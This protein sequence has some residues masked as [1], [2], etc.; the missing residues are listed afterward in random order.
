MTKSR[1]TGITSL[2]LSAVLC[3]TGCASGVGSTQN[4]KQNSSTT[5]I[6]E[7]EDMTDCEREFERFLADKK[8]FPVSF[9]YGGV[10][11]DGL[12]GFRT[13]V[14]KD[15][16]DGA[17][18]S[19]ELKYAHPDGK[20]QLTVD[21]AVYPEYDA[22]EWTVYFKNIGESNSAVLS[23]VWGADFAFAGKNPILKWN[24]GDYGGHFTPHSTDL[25]EQKAV[26]EANT[27]RSSEQYMPYFDL[28]TDDGGFM[29][30]VGWPG[31][32]RTEFS[33]ENGSTR[34][35]GTGTTGLKTY[36]KPGETVRTALMA[37]VRYYER[38]EDKAI[39][40]WRRWYIDCNMPYETAEKTNKVPA[41]SI[42]FPSSDTD[43]GWYRGGSEYE[44]YKTWRETV[45]VLKAHDV[46]FDIH[47]FDAGWYLNADKNTLGLWWW[48][49]GT[50][51]LDPA[52]WPGDT[53]KEYNKAVQDELGVK[54]TNMW[55]ESDRAK[56]PICA[57]QKNY[58]ADPS[59]YLPAPGENYL[60]NYAADGASDWIFGRITN[61]M[62]KGGIDI[63]RED[64]NF[65]PAPAFKA[66]DA[67]EGKNRTGITENKYFI[68]KLAMWD[69]I[70]AWQAATGRPTFIEMQAAGGNRLDLELFRR[71]ISFFRSDSDIQ[72]DPPF[73][74]SKVNALN[75]WVPYGGVLF[76]KLSGSD[77]TNGRTKYQWRSCYASQMAVALQFRK[78]DDAMWELVKNGLEE[79]EKYKQ[80]VLKDFYELTPWKPL[81]DREQWVARM[82]FDAERDRGVLEVFNAPNS[83]TNVQKIKLKGVD[84]DGIYTLTDPDG[85]NGI[86][87]IKGS[88]LLDG[89]DIRL[90]AA[91]SAI[92]WI[93]PANEQRS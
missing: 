57:L 24:D 62:E 21:A 35:L 69:R 45:D 90:D 3:M 14:R 80:F 39:N 7:S 56:G 31:T 87:E 18:R 70:L 20:L 71:S 67:F 83:T 89:I 25:S 50:W 88:E 38:D 78:M 37:F 81:Y 43:H 5:Y 12:S 52:K 42:L 10:Y 91:S 72:L 13:L 60:F 48:D 32:W 68:G 2:A 84:P 27:G 49:V 15:T 23:D 92:L 22:Y 30:A 64:H 6:T 55:F 28:E 4:G 59:W 54:Y 47:H 85:Q 11:Y 53:L 34:V 17:K 65:S 75:K 63:Y 82:Y 66:G 93:D 41:Y 40:K 19:I 74:V 86:A 36:L 16:E 73:T 29:M 61:A 46:K 77:S 58:G 26:F 33:Y 76:G 79:Y 51:D 1:I 9:V 44:S 8:N